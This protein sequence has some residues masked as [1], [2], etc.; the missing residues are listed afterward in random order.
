[1]RALKNTKW[2]IQKNVKSFGDSLRDTKVKKM[3]FFDE[4]NI[5]RSYIIWINYSLNLTDY[6]VDKR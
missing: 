3:G 5:L 2:K 1:M 4:R 6:F